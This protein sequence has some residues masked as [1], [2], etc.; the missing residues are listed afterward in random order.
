[1][2]FLR[3][4]A[5]LSALAVAQRRGMSNSVEG[6]GGVS[7]VLRASVGPPKGTEIGATPASL[8]ERHRGVVVLLF[9]SQ[10]SKRFPVAA[11]G[12]CQRKAYD[13][14]DDFAWQPATLE[15]Y[16]QQVLEGSVAGA[17]CLVYFAYPP[18]FLRPQLILSPRLTHL[19][20]EMFHIDDVPL[21]HVVPTPDRINQLA[22]VPGVAS[23]V[24]R[25]RRSCILPATG[26][27]IM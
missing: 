1:M 6:E 15:G 23:P 3:V 7:H 26:R 5:S 17:D 14:K 2:G 9:S 20:R 8:Q 24:F 10:K 19:R 13:L 18:F 25:S 27:T 16:F 22:H 12:V 21:R 11:S 4:S